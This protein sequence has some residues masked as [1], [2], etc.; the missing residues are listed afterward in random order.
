LGCGTINQAD[1]PGGGMQCTYI[2]VA[3][4]C[5]ATNK[6]IELEKPAEIDEILRDGTELF[7]AHCKDEPKYLTI[8]ELSPEIVVRGTLYKQHLY[9]ALTGLIET[10]QS[11]SFSLTFSLSDA[12]TKAFSVASACYVTM[13]KTSEL[14][15]SPAYTHA[16]VNRDNRFM[17]FD[18]HGRNTD[19]LSSVSGVAVLLEMESVA[20]LVTHIEKLAKSL[21][22]SINSPFE[23]I[24]VDIAADGQIPR[25]ELLMSMAKNAGLPKGADCSG[26]LQSTLGIQASSVSGSSLVSG[27]GKI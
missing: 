2:S 11:E 24:P 25:S 22:L 21:C 19:G 18:S 15:E 13:H 5:L 16:V 6:E 8:D 17:F 7:F 4:L 20:S 9:E 12:L 10:K 27:S 26:L 23:V 3:F 1:I 14:S